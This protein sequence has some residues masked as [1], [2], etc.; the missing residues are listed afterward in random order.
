MTSNVR[1]EKTLAQ[2]LEKQHCRVLSEAE[3]LKV[4]FVC[5][6]VCVPAPT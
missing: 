1:L 2:Q 3:I 6:G 4:L 5:S